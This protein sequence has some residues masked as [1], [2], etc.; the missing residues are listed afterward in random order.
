MRTERVSFRNGRVDLL[1]HLR[2]PDGFDENKTYTAFI[3]FT[4][5]SSVKKRSGQAAGLPLDAG[6]W[7]GGSE[8]VS[9]TEALKSKM[10]PAAAARSG[11]WRRPVL[12]A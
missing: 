12:S 9:S 2:L 6:P 10:N 11:L 4:P 8:P 1:G 5:G 3:I 7:R